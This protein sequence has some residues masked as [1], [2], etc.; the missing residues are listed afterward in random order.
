MIAYKGVSKNLE[1]LLGRGYKFEEGKTVR[2]ERAKCAAGGFHCAENP[3]DC[4]A[5]YRIS[6][7]R[8]FMVEAAG[9]IDEDAFDT[10]IAC[11]EITLLKELSIAE[12]A[13]YGM[14]YMIEHPKR[15]WVK[16]GEAQVRPEKAEAHNSWSIAIA[17]GMDPRVKGSIL[18]LLREPEP[19]K[20]TGAKIFRVAGE[21]KADTWY[22]LGDSQIKEAED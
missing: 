9:N 6:Q 14:K 4:F 2:E 15:E 3:F 19:G 8:F 16:Q 7:S 1:A 17:R 11:T 10:K 22:V 13:V 18:G 12:M 21:I 5:Y 20:F